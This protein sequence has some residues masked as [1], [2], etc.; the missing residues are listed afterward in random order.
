M[1]L[2]SKSLSDF[3]LPFLRNANV[4]FFE[5]DREKR[6]RAFAVKKNAYPGRSEHPL[7]LAL[8]INIAS[9]PEIRDGFLQTKAGKWVL[10]HGHEYGFIHRY[11]DDKGHITGY[12]FEAWHFRYVGPELATTLYENDQ[13]LEEYYGKEQILPE[14]DE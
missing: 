6:P 4:Q 2:R 3:R 5:R 9:D 11:P 14:K 10:E 7:G 13:T 8:D 1:R 12:G